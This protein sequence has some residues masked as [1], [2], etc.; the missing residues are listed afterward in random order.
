MKKIII[1]SFL[2]L[3]CIF[4]TGCSSNIPTEE[5]MSNNS[6]TNM[7]ESYQADKLYIEP[8]SKVIYTFSTEILDKD[9]GRQNNIRLTCASLNGTIVKSGETFSFCDTVGKATKDKGYQEAKI[10]DADGNVIMGLRWWKLSS[11]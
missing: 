2:I 6:S 4:L 3:S 5:N 11:K 1:F 7:N 8:S 9:P 10:F